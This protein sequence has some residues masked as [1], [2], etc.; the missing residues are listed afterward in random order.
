ME[1]LHKDDIETL[2]N[3]IKTCLDNGKADVASL[4][5]LR[6]DQSYSPR[7]KL[8][9]YNRFFDIIEDWSKA[10]VRRNKYALPMV[11]PLEINTKRFFSEGGFKKLF[12]EQQEKIRVENVLIEKELDEA[13]VIKWTKK[14]YWLSVIIVA[15]SFVISV[16]ALI[17]AIL[18]K[19]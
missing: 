15:L 4:P 9:E 18:K 10:E 6:N 11:I 12:K 5:D 7:I 16:I 17:V 19:P 2:D 14:T 8:D 1:L 3:I 13:K